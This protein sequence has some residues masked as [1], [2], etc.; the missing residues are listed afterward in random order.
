MKKTVN[1]LEYIVGINAI[2]ANFVCLW[3]VGWETSFS[4]LLCATR[5]NFR[6]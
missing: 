3:N 4:S 5:E 1:I 2:I 6:V